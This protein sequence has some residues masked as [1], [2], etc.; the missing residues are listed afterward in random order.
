MIP[1]VVCAFEQDGQRLRDVKCLVEIG[2][3]WFDPA[4]KLRA[5]VDALPQ[6]FDTPREADRDHFF[7]GS[8]AS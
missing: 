7:T 8:I 3:H 4:R 5:S 2:F 1:N 6:S